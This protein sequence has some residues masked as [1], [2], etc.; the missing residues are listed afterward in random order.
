MSYFR[1]L[2]A[3]PDQ[4]RID[5]LTHGVASGG[6]W[7][8]TFEN[9]PQ[10]V[11]ASVRGA[12]GGSGMAFILAADFVLAS[13]TSFFTVAHVRI[14]GS[15]DGGSTYYL[16]RLIGSR[17]AK[18]LCLLGDRIDARQAQELG[19][20]TELLPDDQLDQ[21]TEALVSR[22]NTAATKALAGTKNLINDSFNNDLPAQL[23]LEA[24]AF[25]RSAATA[26]FLEGVAA[27]VEKRRP[28]FTG[29]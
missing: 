9:M 3:L 1:K 5:V 24:E 4:E 27:F 17:Q 18:K 16:P 28:L 23:H 6:R 26:D 10:P 20:L 19:L 21:A 14:G 8:E 22:L 13:D 2:F 25:G 15:T 12:V 11:V 7:M 29:N